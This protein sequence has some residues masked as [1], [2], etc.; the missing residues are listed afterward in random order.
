[1]KFVNV[2]IVSDEDLGRKT[3]ATSLLLS[4]VTIRAKVMELLVCV[5]R[6]KVIKDYSSGNKSVPYPRTLYLNKIAP[7]EKNFSQ[8]TKK[9]LR[10]SFICELDVGEIET[11]TLNDELDEDFEAE[12]ADSEEVSYYEV[13]AHH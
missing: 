11:I 7:L 8:L 13:S 3:E 5:P 4:E 9:I 1:M 2:Y 12:M 10:S 6:V